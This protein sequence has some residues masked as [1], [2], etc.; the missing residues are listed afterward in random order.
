MCLCVSVC[1]CVCVCVCACVSAC[2]HVCACVSASEPG[3]CFLGWFWGVSD[4][5]GKVPQESS[6]P[7]RTSESPVGPLHKLLHK[8]SG[9]EVCV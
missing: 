7:G 6:G 2:V 4:Y 3:L 8:L 9:T 5:F 1:V